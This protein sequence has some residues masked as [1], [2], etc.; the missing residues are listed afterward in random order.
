MAFSIKRQLKKNQQARIVY[1]E[2]YYAWRKFSTSTF[3]FLLKKLKPRVITREQLLEQSTKCNLQ[4]FGNRELVDF[5]DFDTFEPV[6]EIIAK[7]IY[8]MQTEIIQPFVCEIKNAIIVGSPPIAFDD[9]GQLILETTLPIF[10]T[11]EVHLAKNVSLKSLIINQ[12]KSVKHRDNPIEVA[13][14]FTNAWSSNFWHWTVDN[15]TQLE[16]LE[17][18]EQ[19]TGM[20]PKLIVEGNMRSWQ[21]DSLALLGYKEE[22]L[23][24]SDNSK[25]LVKKLIVPSF[26]RAYKQTHGEISV[27]ACRWLRQKIL[28]NI[29]NVTDLKS[30]HK[31][32]EPKILI[33][34]SK[35]LGRRVINENE[36]MEALSPLGFSRYILED[37][38]YGDQ[39]RLFAQA[40]VIIAPHGAGLTNLLFADNP[41]IIELFSSYVG[42]EFANLSRGLGFKYGCLGCQL[43]PGE[44]RQKE[45]DMIVDINQLLD[46]LEYRY[47]FD[48]AR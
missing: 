27:S 2:L 28:S 3:T 4:K 24:I 29:S 32:F 26:R 15:L 45:G 8:P 34:R 18:Y 19:Q 5:G 48:L 6:P 12:F 7:M 31:S 22:D 33:S 20:K 16:G 44:V 17:Y 14:I 37:M 47:E 21:K 39:V 10:N 23:I 41:I 46:L 25:R 42:R 30:E 9:E 1:R 36:V 38:S 40:K 11:P 13:S 35:A 43:P